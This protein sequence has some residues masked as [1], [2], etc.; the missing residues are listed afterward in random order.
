MQL[1]QLLLHKD[2]QGIGYAAWPILNEANHCLSTLLAKKFYK[3]TVCCI[4][5]SCACEF[6][7]TREPSVDMRVVGTWKFQ[8]ETFF[9]KKW[10]LIC[11]AAQPFYTGRSCYISYGGSWRSNRLLANLGAELKKSPR[12][13]KS[14]SYGPYVEIGSSLRKGFHKL[15]LL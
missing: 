13:L 2:L 9:V 4:D 5:A 14:I 8:V 15:Y 11:C 7:N 10:E 6:S 12:I 1:H 3:H